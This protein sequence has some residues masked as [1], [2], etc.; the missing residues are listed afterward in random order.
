MDTLRDFL[1]T[2][3]PR[4]T[5]TQA[6]MVDASSESIRFLTQSETLALDSIP[7]EYDQETMPF[8]TQMDFGAGKMQRISFEVGEDW[9]APK[10]LEWQETAWVEYADPLEIN[11]DGSTVYADFRLD[12]DGIYTLVLRDQISPFFDTWNHW[13]N[14]YVE[15]LWRAFVIDGKSAHVFAPESEVTRA[16]FLK[17][18]LNGLDMEVSGVPVHFSDMESG[19][20][21]TQVVEEGLAAGVITGYP[22][23]T[24]RPNASINRAEAVAM[25][26]RAAQLNPVESIAANYT[27]VNPTE[28]YSIYVDIATTEEVVSGYGDGTFGPQ[29]SLKRGEAAKVIDGVMSL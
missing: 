13:S 21:Y 3:E 27:D 10:L 7:E 17:M 20:W 26:I 5:Q 18:V 24:F 1:S 19:A 28:W 4:S 22:D 29:N 6:I 9:I 14:V 15:S 12:H 8:Q 11:T 23:G 25:V 2:F 16:E